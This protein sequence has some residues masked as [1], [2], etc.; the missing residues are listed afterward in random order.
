MGL[1]PMGGQLCVQSIIEQTNRNA[2]LPTDGSA[3]PGAKPTGMR[4]CLQT[5]VPILE[6][7]QHEY[8]LFY[9]GSG[10]KTACSKGVF[11]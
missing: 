7:N 1:C 3:D 8:G 10:M 6:Q 9:T 11:S 4:L 2:P 5:K